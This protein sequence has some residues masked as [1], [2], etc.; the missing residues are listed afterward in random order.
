[1]IPIDELKNSEAKDYAYTIED[2][3]L[4]NSICGAFICCI[5]FLSDNLN[6][7]KNTKRSIDEF[8][9]NKSYTT[10]VDGGISQ[11]DI[12]LFELTLKKYSQ[13][14]IKEGWLPKNILDDISSNLSDKKYA[15]EDIDKFEILKKMTND[16]LDN[17]RDVPQLTDEGFIIGR[18]I[19]LT[20]L[21]PSPDDLKHSVSSSL[22]PGDCVLMI[23][24][25]LIGALFGFETL[26]NDYKY[27]NK[28]VYNF[29]A[30]IKS[31][32]LN[33]QSDKYND[34][35]LRIDEEPFG[36]FGKKIKLIYQDSEMIVKDDEGPIELNKVL[37]LAKSSKHKITLEPDRKFNRVK[38]TYQFKDGRSQTVYIESGKPTPSGVKT[39]RIY[40][41]CFD[42]SIKANKEYFKTKME[43]I[44]I[45]SNKPER[46]CRFAIDEE[47]EQ[48]VV[49]RDQIDFSG[50]SGD[51][52]FLEH[53]AKVA[54]EFEKTFGFDKF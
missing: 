41:P 32:I 16:I 52:D 45:Y 51:L 22:E 48:L 34:A 37:L 28:N 14:D 10:F 5:N 33:Q 38:H 18:A 9:K 44:F 19:L 7:F 36:S 1:L 15:K 17:K 39:L 11:F 43:E 42:L 6:S 4:S 3:N 2:Y 35:D 50:K 13:L 27:L 47:K 20:L 24:S 26:S 49:M 8:L 12:D 31:L 29:G 53:V 46:W 25:F 30:Q 23:S 54:D 40:S 21:R